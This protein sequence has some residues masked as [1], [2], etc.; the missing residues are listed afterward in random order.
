MPRRQPPSK[1]LAPGIPVLWNGSPQR[2]EDCAMLFS[3][4][5]CQTSASGLVN[6]DRAGAAHGLAWV[7]DGAT[8][9][10]GT[11]L[12][13]AATDADW[14]AGRLN[15]ALKRLSIARRCGPAPTAFVRRLRQ[16]VR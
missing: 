7:I 8:D 1:R 5:E 16:C 3:I 4:A 12:T 9:V 15:A 13:G 14:I 2:G 6:E 10:A 11:P